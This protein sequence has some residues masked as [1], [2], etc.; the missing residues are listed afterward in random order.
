MPSSTNGDA[1][2]MAG[3]RL[4]S[5]EAHAKL[6][7]VVAMPGEPALTETFIRAHIE[8]IPATVVPVSGWPLRISGRRPVLSWPSRAAYKAWRIVSGSATD[9]VTRAYLKVF[10]SYRPCAVLAEYGLTGVG[11]LAACRTAQVPLVVH[12]H[13]YDASMH[14]VLAA[15]AQTYPALFDQA[16]AIVVVSEAMRRKLIS[17]GAPPEKLH[18]NPCGVDCRQ[19]VGG[20]PANA[21]PRFIA[22]GRFTEKKGPDLT[23][24]AFATLR[25]LYPEAVLTMIGDGPMLA[26][27][28]TLASD[29]GIEGGVTFLGAQPAAVVRDEMRR[30]R[31]FVQH[32]VE[33]PSGDCEGTPVSI[34]EAGATG[35]PV[36]STRHGG[37]PDVVV[38]GRTGFLVAEHDVEGMAHHMLRITRDPELAGRFGRAARLRVETHFSM[39]GSIAELWKIIY[40]C[41]RL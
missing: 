39:E 33:A 26:S 5:G 37:I 7:L 22:V 18:C 11:V 27:C 2:R 25:R 19:F 34:L 15:H 14:E 28:R 13:G 17:L 8:R 36:V 24:R 20:Q 31:C 10:R 30:A 16:A 1:P 41:A 12:F 4:V 23:L 3:D 29:L 9:S 6:S 21:P 38:E 35:L 32:S 40:S